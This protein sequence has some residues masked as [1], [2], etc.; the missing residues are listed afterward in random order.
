[1]EEVKKVLNKYSVALVLD[2]DTGIKAKA[3]MIEANSRESAVGIALFK[4]GN[5]I[6]MSWD[7]TSGR[8]EVDVDEAV[9]PFLDQ[10]K[11]IHAI[12]EVRRLTGMGFREAR[13]YIINM[14]HPFSKEWK[15]KIKKRENEEEED[16]QFW[17][18]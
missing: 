8:S 11:P 2:T 6:V 7:I 16:V 5:E 3:F 15:E 10:E 14:D 13:D 4:V 9:L 1:M 12:R 18:P 17:Q